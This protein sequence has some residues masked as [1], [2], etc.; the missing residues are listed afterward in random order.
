[1]KIDMVFI[2]QNG[3]V[4][5]FDENKKQ[6]PELQG[7]LFDLDFRELGKHIHKDTE[8][9]VGSSSKTDIEW[10]LKRQGRELE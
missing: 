1:M 7:F 9:F 6:V 2:F 10:W 4:A 8:L 5:V 3:M